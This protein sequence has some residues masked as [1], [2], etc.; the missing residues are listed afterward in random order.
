MWVG[1]SILFLWGEEKNKI[2]SLKFVLT[3]QKA[4]FFLFPI[5]HYRFYLVVC[6]FTLVANG[7]RYEKLPIS[8]D[9]LSIYTK[10]EAGY[11]P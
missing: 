8:G 3:C 9:F 6:R 11:N 1:F 5:Y 2:N 4:K 10:A 7:W